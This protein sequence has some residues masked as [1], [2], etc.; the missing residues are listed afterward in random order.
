[1]ENEDVGNLDAHPPWIRGEKCLLRAI[2][3]RTIFDL[4]DPS[5]KNDTL[6]WVTQEAEE[7]EEFTLPWICANL[8]IDFKATIKALVLFSLTNKSGIKGELYR[9]EV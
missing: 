6:D 8:D 1:M 7:D 4:T 3:E 5:L 9:G 2:L